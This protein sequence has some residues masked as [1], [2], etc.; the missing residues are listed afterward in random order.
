MAQTNARLA[1][2]FVVFMLIVGV[3]V[4]LAT[5][6]ST[7][8]SIEPLSRSTPLVEGC[9]F[10]VPSGDGCAIAQSSD[11]FLGRVIA[12]RI[13]DDPSV[14]LYGSRDV[15]YTVAVVS[16]FRG[17]ATGSVEV[18]Q[19]GGYSIIPGTPSTEPRH[20]LTQGDEALFI[21][22]FDDGKYILFQGHYG[23]VELPEESAR[24][25]EVV[26][27]TTYVATPTP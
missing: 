2:G 24:A 26:R 6:R 13:A 9:A 1:T 12:N 3:V 25:T 4:Y 10:I 21:T 19:Y 5:V 23:Y 11:V 14:P 15:F 7:G 22:S 16:T 17:H 27:L 18:Y 20:V 8:R